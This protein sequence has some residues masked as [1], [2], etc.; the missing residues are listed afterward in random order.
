M[1]TGR[2]PFQRRGPS[3][4]LGAGGIIQ[5]GMD[6]MVGEFELPDD[7]A[8][9]PRNEAGDPLRVVLENVTP[10]NFLEV[11]WRMNFKNIS[12]YY[13]DPFEVQFA[14]VVTFDGSNPDIDTPSPETLLLFNSGATSAFPPT[15]EGFDFTV[16]A[17]TV[18]MAEI[19]EGATTATV[20]LV[21]LG[22]PFALETEDEEGEPSENSG[23]LKA[24]E[25]SASAVA[26]S[27]GTF[28][29]VDF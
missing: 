11:D 7:E 12:Y 14:V 27:V 29:P 6:E 4:P 9:V 21:Y 10:G 24:T 3:G 15:G 17:N 23:T 20:Q 26:Q 28:V 22:G 18:A 16:D 2:R 8:F 13:Q 5:I 19:P 1:A 25:I